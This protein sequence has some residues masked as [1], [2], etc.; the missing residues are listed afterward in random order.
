MARLQTDIAV[1][2]AL[3]LTPSDLQSEDVPRVHYIL[4]Q[5]MDYFAVLMEGEPGYNPEASVY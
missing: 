3:P 2:F 4:G 1:M 5:V